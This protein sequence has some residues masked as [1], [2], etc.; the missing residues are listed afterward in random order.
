MNGEL[1]FSISTEGLKEKGQE[2]ERLAKTIREA[3]NDINDARTSL[4]GWVSVNKDRYD[5]RIG[6]AL[7]KMN[8]LVDTISSYSKVAVQTSE[9]ATAVEDK[10][11]KAIDDNLA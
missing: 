9:N 8:E 1:N 7:P 2:I 11:A 5:S 6:N 3:L 10:I 4:E